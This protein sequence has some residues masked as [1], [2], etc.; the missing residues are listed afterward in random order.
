MLVKE[1]MEEEE[2]K[3]KG[4]R[5]ARGWVLFLWM[6]AWIDGRMCQRGL[7]VVLGGI[8]LSRSKKVR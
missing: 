2:K 5:N 8:Y 4:G 3:K 1:M 6:E 7:V